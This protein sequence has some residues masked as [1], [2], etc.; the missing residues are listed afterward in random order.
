MV[1]ILYVFPSRLHLERIQAVKYCWLA[2][3]AMCCCRQ[4]ARSGMEASQI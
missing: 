4:D 3:P 1:L 2:V